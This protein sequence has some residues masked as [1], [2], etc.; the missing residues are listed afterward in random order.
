[1]DEKNVW[2]CIKIFL[3][4]YLA[5]HIILENPQKGNGIRGNQANHI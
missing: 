4:E 5:L 1:M 3:V 2:R